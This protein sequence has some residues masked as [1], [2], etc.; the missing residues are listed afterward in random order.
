[1]F[2]LS[3]YAARLHVDDEVNEEAGQARGRPCLHG[4]E[5]TSG[6]ALEVRLDEGGPRHPLGLVGFVE[7]SVF[8]HDAADGLSRYFVAEFL[9]FAVDVA[10]AP[11][12]V[13]LLE[14]QHEFADLVGL[15][16][17]GTAF[18][19]TVVLT[20][21]QGAMPFQECFRREQK[22]ALLEGVS[23]YLDGG[24]CQTTFLFDVEEETFLAQ[25]FAEHPVL[26]HEV[27][28]HVLL[29]AVHPSGQ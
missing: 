6:H 18:T 4:E 24:G 1:M 28:D 3:R 10:V 25:L 29:L 5:V 11:V 21:D 20:S 14:S 17:F 9:E 2:R 26:F 7:Q 16:R 23:A 19:S 27:S 13:L 8:S 12:G 22:N 15:L